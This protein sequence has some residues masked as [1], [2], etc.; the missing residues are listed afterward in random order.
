MSIAFEEY[1][2]IHEDPDAD[3]NIHLP[4]A[5]FQEGKVDRFTRLVVILC[6]NAPNTD[7]EHGDPL[8]IRDDMS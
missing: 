7:E 2:D 3:S 4:K 1:D 6:D 8:C 5:P